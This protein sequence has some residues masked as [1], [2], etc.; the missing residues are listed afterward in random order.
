MAVRVS[1]AAPLFLTVTDS[2]ALV[3]PATCAAK[4]TEVGVKV[5]G[6]V[7]PPE[8]VPDRVTSCGE[9]AELSVMERPPLMA[10]LAVGVKVTARLHLALAASDAP[11]VVPLE[12][13]A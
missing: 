5:R 13:M 3:V 9:N 2:A 6:G 11:Q 8:P 7:P 1:E 10:P 12:A 4:V